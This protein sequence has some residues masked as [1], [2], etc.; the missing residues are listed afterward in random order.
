MRKY[1]NKTVIDSF[2]LFKKYNSLFPN[3]F[4]YNGY[5]DKCPKCGRKVYFK[6]GL[7]NKSKNAPENSHPC[8]LNSNSKVKMNWYKKKKPNIKIYLGYH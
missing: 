1:R 5:F 8:I 6:T 4:L 3:R 7:N 2:Y